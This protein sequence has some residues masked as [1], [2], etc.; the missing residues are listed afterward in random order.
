MALDAAIEEAKRQ[1]AGTRWAWRV[2]ADSDEGT[3]QGLFARGAQQIG[4]MPVMA[5]DV[6]TVADLDTPADL[7]IS[8]VAEPAEMREYAE[9]LGF[10]DGSVDSVVDRELGLA[11]PDVVRLAGIVDGRTVATLQ[12]SSDGEPVHRR[13]GF[14]VVS[15]CLF[16]LAQ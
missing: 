6:T 10:E 1:L 11:Y 2:G 16:A 3:A 9:P 4:E 12:A 14:E 15:R 5:I 13:M 7:K 8:T